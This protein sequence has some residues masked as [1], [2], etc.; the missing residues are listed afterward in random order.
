MANERI[1][2]ASVATEQKLDMTDDRGLSDLNK[3][4]DDSFG[5]RD[6]QSPA[7]PEPEPVKDRAPKTG[8]TSVKA[9]GTRERGS[10]GHHAPVEV[11][12]AERGAQEGDEPLNLLGE[13]EYRAKPRDRKPIEFDEEIPSKTPE[14]KKTSSFPGRDEKS[15]KFQ[16]AKPASAPVQEEEEPEKE[17]E[18]DPEV[19]AVIAKP[20]AH[21]NVKEGIQRLKTIAR[22]RRSEIKS[23]TSKAQQL[24]AELDALKKTGLS[25]ETQKELDRLRATSQRFDLL[26]DPQFKTKYEDPVEAAGDRV[27]KFCVDLSEGNAEIK[28]WAEETKKFGFKNL[29]SDYWDKE[30]IPK[31]AS[32]TNQQRVAQ[33]AADLHAKIDDRN[34]MVTEFTA[35][36]DKIQEYRNQQALE[37]YTNYQQE[38]QDECNK[39]VSQIGDWAQLK[40]VNKAKTDEERA[41]Y[42]EHNHRVENYKTLFEKTMGDV[43]HGGARKQVRI[44][45]QAVFGIER[46]REFKELKADYEALEAEHDALRNQYNRVSRSRSVP[47]RTGG[48]V[49]VKPATGLSTKDARTALKE[50]FS[51]GGS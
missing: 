42:D 2:S 10:P 9:P 38:A 19:D 49:D 51:G 32:I 3:A 40:D 33:L 50:Y 36:P 17:E 22:A 30:I 37:Y 39:L 34:R 12:R 13:R 35:T 25:P 6:G 18:D 26:N 48:S 41:L 8:Q 11:K 47:G 24:S 43:M 21:P 20:N 45:A 28:R 27:L 1:E 31:I 29:S 14:E 15:G 5:P 4:F 16:K 7:P 46:D 44:V 23:L